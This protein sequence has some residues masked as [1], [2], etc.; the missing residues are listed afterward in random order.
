[1]GYHFIPKA[2]LD[3]F[4]PDGHPEHV[5][6]YDAQD[7]RWLNDGRRLPTIAVSQVKSPW[8]E[9]REQQLADDEAQAMSVIAKLC[10]QESITSA[11]HQGLA[12]YVTMMLGHRSPK[13]WSQL[14]KEIP[15]Q[16]D[17]VRNNLSERR[18][19]AS[20]ADVAKADEWF[21]REASEAQKNPYRSKSRLRDEGMEGVARAVFHSLISMRWTVLRAVRGRFVICDSPV[22]STIHAGIGVGYTAGQVW[23]PL[24]QTDLLVASW[25]K[26]P[27][28]R[29]NGDV[30]YKNTREVS[31]YNRAIVGQVYR[32]IYCSEKFP[33]LPEQVEEMDVEGE[34]QRASLAILSPASLESNSVLVCEKCRRIL[35][36]CGCPW[37][38][39]DPPKGAPVV[40]AR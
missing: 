8:S 20:K 36:E 11:E 38:M 3:R 26:G 10:R 39:V 17:E 34:S 7:R 29:N 40:R 35:L 27:Q 25:W 13:M 37:G 14:A 18:K 2:H 30:S 23:A 16:L 6:V 5:Y 28:R 32:Y 15:K 4:S 31:K 33:W 19:T 21:K 1:M 22:C 9:S 24:S 12:Y